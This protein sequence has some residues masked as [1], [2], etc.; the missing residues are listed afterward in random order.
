MSKPAKKPARPTS[1]PIGRDSPQRA[2][3]A[4][5]YGRPPVDNQF[6]EGN[7]A[8]PNGRPVG[9]KSQAAVLNE[10]LNRK[11]RITERDGSKKRITTLQA[12]I[13]T[14]VREA[15]KGNQKA[16]EFLLKYHRQVEEGL[17]GVDQLDADDQH[18]LEILL[19]EEFSKR[20]KGKK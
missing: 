5:G 13:M 8:N 2:T 1:K 19:N 14:Q 15:L 9:A 4:V 7:N 6:K 16:A 10:Q 17:L 20:A 3:Y 18:A 12:I 11:I